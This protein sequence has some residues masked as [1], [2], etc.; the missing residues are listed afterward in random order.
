MTKTRLLYQFDIDVLFQAVDTQNDYEILL[1]INSLKEEYEIKGIWST[2]EYFVAI[3]AKIASILGLP[4]ANPIATERCR[5]KLL[6]RQLLLE[7]GLSC[8]WFYKIE[9]TKKLSE[10]VDKILY[11]CIIKPVDGSGS[12][13]VKLCNSKNELQESALTLFNRK[14]NERGL[15]IEKYILCEEYIVGDEFSAEVFNGKVIGFAKKH[16]GKLPYFIE[17]G[18]DFPHIFFKNQHQSVVND[19]EYIVKLFDLTFGPLSCR[20]FV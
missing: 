11:P 4:S 10:V 3:V 8:P 6:Q 12:T 7:N 2:S 19:I 9:N 16:L 20:I 14:T 5:N 1:C 13:G 15:K 18:H 17:K